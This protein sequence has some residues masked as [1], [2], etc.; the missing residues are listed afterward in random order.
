MRN[1]LMALI[2]AAAGLAIPAALRAQG[3]TETNATTATGPDISGV[4]RQHAPPEARSYALYTFTKESAPMT[5]WALE[6]F[7]QAKPSFGPRS[8]PD[9]NDPV[10]PTTG[11]SVGC[12]PPG[13]PRIYL[14]PFPMEII[15]IPGR[16]LILY[17]FDHFFRQI[18]TD[19]RG[20]D[21]A[22]PET[23]MG[24]SIGH[25]EGD[26]LVVDTVNF[27]DKTWLDRGGVP[28]SNKLHVVEHFHRVN[29]DTLQID[30]TMEDPIALTRPWSGTQYF[31][32]RPKWNIMEMVCEDNANFMGIAKELAKPAATKP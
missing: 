1:C 19:G 18:W 3:T 32:L 10:N 11:N 24:D 12:F 5:P 31:Q 21:T 8:S 13:V 27:N 15:Q 14:Q 9:S 29:A 4:W 20:H 6:K 28:H 26:T 2:L 23:Y 7:K 22:L 17:E 25:W 16:V 30:I